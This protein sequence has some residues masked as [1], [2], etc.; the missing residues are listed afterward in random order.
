MAQPN[1]S[2]EF[3]NSG[4][5]SVSIGADNICGLICTGVAVSGKLTLG[6]VVA[7]SSLD[8]AATY[9]ITPAYDE[10][11]SLK[12]YQHI[13]DFY[14]QAPRG[15]LLWLSVFP[16]T[17]Y[18]SDMTYVEDNIIPNL[19][20]ASQGKVSLIGITRTPD[21]EYGES[22]STVVDGDITDVWFDADAFQAIQFAQ[23]TA[24]YQQTLYRYVRFIIEGRNAK[25]GYASAFDLTT[26][27]CPNVAVMTTNSTGGIYA[28]VGLALGRAA[29]LPV[30]RKIA[31]RLDGALNRVTDQYLSSG[32]KDYAQPTEIAGWHDKG[33]LQIIPVQGLVGL[34]FNN[35]LCCTAS[36]DDQQF[37]SRGRVIDKAAKLAVATYNRYVNSEVDVDTDGKLT[38][39]YVAMFESLVEREIRQQMIANKEL[40]G[41]NCYINPDQNVLG[42]STVN[43]ELQ[44]QP[45]GY[46]SYIVVK[47]KFTQ[48]L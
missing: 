19:L 25:D 46:A 21:S 39:E 48:T 5:G 34:Y 7:L 17:T 15:T 45:V 43:M 40:S 10:D 29:A 23:E 9:G 3:V 38:G 12:V 22:T 1:V 13:S 41:V 33:Y 44:L 47:I 4:L 27:N 28:A 30:Q 35:D 36:N 20:Q 31:Y 37:L 26:L 14:S 42:T 8:D 32:T 11:N 6:D 24:A 16:K 2:V 18:M